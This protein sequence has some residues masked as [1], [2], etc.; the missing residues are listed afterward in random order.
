MKQIDY[1]FWKV[2]QTLVGTSGAG[3]EN[4]TC[5]EFPCNDR[6]VKDGSEFGI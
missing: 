2:T 3:G 1:N 5:V 6:I 4:L